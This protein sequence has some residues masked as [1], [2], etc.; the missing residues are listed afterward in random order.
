MLNRL[1][2]HH[3]VRRT[4]GNA[5]FYVYADPTVCD[6]LYVGDQAAYDNY[7]SYRQ[8]KMLADEQQMTAGEYR[9]ATWNW[10]AWGPDDRPRLGRMEP[11][12]G[13]YNAGW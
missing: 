9:D 1:P 6:C 8:Q 3:F 4:H 11:V 12:M 5:V 13:Q 7:Q 10:N 2:P